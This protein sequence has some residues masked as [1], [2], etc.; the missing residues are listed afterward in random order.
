MLLCTSSVLTVFV[1]SHVWQF[2]AYQQWAFNGR[3]TVWFL[4]VILH[5][6]TSHNQVFLSLAKS[7]WLRQCS[8]RY[9]AQKKRSDIP[10]W[11]PH[12]TLLERHFGAV[13]VSW[14]VKVGH[15][16]LFCMLHVDC[17]PPLK[18]W[19]THG[20]FY[21]ESSWKCWICLFILL[22]IRQ[23]HFHFTLSLSM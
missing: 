21:N 12:F 4:L 3:P 6:H 17:K 18:K 5:V 7:G 14:L 1:Y 20:L 13:Y 9:H 15:A 10:I 11:H 23:L 22:K 2:V 8:K 19:Q 16:C